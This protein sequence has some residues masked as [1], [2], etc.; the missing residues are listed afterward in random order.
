M[1][2]GVG[3]AFTCAVIDT[4]CSRTVIDERMA[5]LL[6]LEIERG[7]GEQYGT[8]VACGGKVQAYVG[9]LRG[10]LSC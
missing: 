8:Y 5:E 3:R 1:E 7:V 10:W 4:G 6:G 9:V 2:L